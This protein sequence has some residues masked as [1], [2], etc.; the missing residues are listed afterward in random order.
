[1]ER[2]TYNRPLGVTTLGTL[3]TIAGELHVA[4]EVLGRSWNL[5]L[6]ESTGLF[7]EVGAP[8]GTH[9]LL[10]V[11]LL[12]G[13][14]L[15]LL[16]RVAYVGAI[17]LAALFF[18]G[19]AF[20]L[21]DA[22]KHHD[23]RGIAWSLACA[24]LSTVV[25]SY[26]GVRPVRTK[27]FGCS[28]DQK[29][30]SPGRLILAVL[31]CGLL[32]FGAG[33]W[34][35]ISSGEEICDRELVVELIRK[36]I[37]LEIER[38][39][40]PPE[41]G[42]GIELSG[43]FQGL[44][45]EAPILDSRDPGF[46]EGNAL[47]WHTQV[48]IAFGASLSALSPEFRTL[49]EGLEPWHP[50][51]PDATEHELRRFQ[52]DVAGFQPRNRHDT[53]AKHL[54]LADIKSTILIMDCETR[55]YETC[56]CLQIKAG[57]EELVEARS[58]LD[59]LSQKVEREIYAPSYSPRTIPYRRALLGT[60]QTLLKITDDLIADKSREDRGSPIHDPPRPQC[61]NTIPTH[62]DNSIL[63]GRRAVAE[64]IAAMGQRPEL[65]MMERILGQPDFS[66]VLREWGCIAIFDD[67][68]R[69]TAAHT[70]KVVDFQTGRS[71][72]RRPY[73]L[74]ELSEA[75][76]QILGYQRTLGTDPS[77]AFPIFSESLRLAVAA[78]ATNEDTR[79]RFGI[80][81]DA[82]QLQVRKITGSSHTVVAA[83]ALYAVQRTSKGG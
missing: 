19:G 8:V 16:S 10:F 73:S 53:F 68:G 11:C 29:P 39:Q 41:P 3:L 18:C 59:E 22:L 31:T 21:I 54:V 81:R 27:F 48:S 32:L 35:E 14:G 75:R 45:A 12:S 43:G 25:I 55:L 20:W 42:F 49:L 36:N 76:A 60:I 62:P 79:I 9:V 71:H 65:A 50:G 69:L 57:S 1:M 61:D 80:G 4:N 67:A 63:E 58:R 6:G 83:D 72:P 38:P 15:L 37:D 77:V 44:L 56:H 24:L 28:K 66:G 51:A 23:V 30:P 34:Y 40:P 70:L 13:I 26:L 78:A 5:L 7:I 2:K 82:E 74:D 52:T 47:F 33:A 64:M 17:L 46:H